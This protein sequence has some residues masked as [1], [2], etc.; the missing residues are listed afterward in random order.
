M[1]CHT[2]DV[3]P[4][5]KILCCVAFVVTAALGVA[6]SD[7]TPTTV[8]Y[9]GQVQLHA[10]T[11]NAPAIDSSDDIEATLEVYRSVADAAP[12]AIEPEWEVLISGLETAATVVPADPESMARVN[13]AALAGQPAATRIQQYTLDVCGTAIGS[14][15]PSTNPVTMTAPAATQ[16][17]DAEP[18]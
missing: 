10:D 11:I 5:S 6:C 15:P 18:G 4:R 3:A 12:V 13:D 7:D 1:T 17:T 2:C 16:P 14:P 8:G 9:C